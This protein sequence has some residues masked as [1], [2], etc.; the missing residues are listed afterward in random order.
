MAGKGAGAAGAVLRNE[1]FAVDWVTVASSNVAAIGYSPDFA[2]LWVRFHNGSVYA[3]LD[4]PESVY[5]GY[6]SA[7]SKGRYHHY[8]VKDQF[9]YLRVS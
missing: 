4:E 2:R 1:A 8:H 9:G 5:Q 3:F 6:L 7:P